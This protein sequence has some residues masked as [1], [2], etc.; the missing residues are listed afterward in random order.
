MG[1][2]SLYL[3]TPLAFK[4]DDGGVIPLGWSPE[5]FQW[6]SMDGNGTKWL[7]NIAEN[8]KRLS[9]MHDRYRQTTHGRATV[10]SERERDSLKCFKIVQ[11]SAQNSQRTREHPFLPA[12]NW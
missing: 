7:W 3:A 5:T 6:M 4:A 2:K 12:S 9:R 1:P 11:Y 8:F 10:Y